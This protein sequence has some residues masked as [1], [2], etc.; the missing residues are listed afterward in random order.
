MK[1]Y[2]N[3]WG[4]YAAIT[5]LCAIVIYIFAHNWGAAVWALCAG[6]WALNTSILQDKI[7]QLEN[8]NKSK[9]RR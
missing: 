8:S 2:F 6:T 9:G 4:T 5:A 1:K 7:H 3:Y